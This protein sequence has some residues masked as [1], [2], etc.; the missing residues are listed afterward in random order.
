MSR[1]FN[2]V[3]IVMMVAVIIATIPLTVPKIFGYHIYNV[4]TGSM[5]PKYPIGSIVYVKEIEPNQLVT[6]DVITFFL[7]NQ[8]DMVMTHRVV[9]N[10][11][12]EE[13][14]ITKGDANEENDAGSV[15]YENVIGKVTFCVPMLGSF[16]E[17]L[18]ST[19]GKIYII[20][21]FA[22]SFLLWILVDKDRKNTITMVIKT[23]ALAMMVV[24]MVS[25]VITLRGYQIAD[26]EYDSLKNKVMP[27]A[28]KTKQ[29]SAE[30]RFIPDKDIVDSLATL[31]EENSDT[32]GWLS[33]DSV[34][35]DYPLVKAEDNYYYLTRT[36]K[37][38]ENRAGAI[39]MDAGCHDTLLDYHSII[40]G[41]NMK[42]GSMFGKL[43]QYREEEFFYE[44]P[45]FTIYK[46]DGAYRYQ[47]FSAHTIADSDEIYTLWYGN[48]DGFDEF[49]ARMK[50][51]SWY[52]TGV[53][54]S[55]NDRIMTLSTCTAS[56]D[57]R[58]VVHAKLIALVKYE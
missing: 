37:K 26:N 22:L 55:P 39:F 51:N 45:F 17:L 32:V 16:S 49:V 19:K 46:S 48:S 9:E 28:D 2:I 41:H 20:S 8:S 38:T 5:E 27:N 56:D 1:L 35:I 42:N 21:I 18:Q 43:K 15:S 57:Q 10:K 58:F 52:D 44:N 50:R 4:L 29:V 3:G 12:D 33:F 54:V 6:G 23:A 31:K 40:Y 11:V 53:E 36:Y 47:I 34:D 24:A 25:L 14:I 7:A 13:R 30:E